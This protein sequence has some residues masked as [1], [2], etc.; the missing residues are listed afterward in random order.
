MGFRPMEARRL[1]VA[2]LRIRSREDL[3]DAYTSLPSVSAKKNKPRMLQLH[4]EVAAWLV[5]HH[6]RSRFGAEPLFENANAYN[7]EGRWN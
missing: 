3:L 2:D 7:D 6:D 4:P 5:E 1:N